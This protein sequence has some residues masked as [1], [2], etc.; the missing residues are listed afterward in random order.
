MVVAVLA[1]E[2]WLQMVYAEFVRMVVVVV[3]ALQSWHCLWLYFVSTSRHGLLLLV[4]VLMELRL[5]LVDHHCF[6]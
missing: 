3:V 5:P 2:C 4:A 1:V 6:D